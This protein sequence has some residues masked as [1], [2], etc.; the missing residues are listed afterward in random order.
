MPV[1]ERT[2]CASKAAR[3]RLARRVRSIDETAQPYYPSEDDILS[4]EGEQLGILEVP[5]NGILVDYVTGEEM[6][7]MFQANWSSGALPEP[8]V[9]S[10]GYHNTFSW[11][12][13]ERLHMVMD[14]L[15][16]HLASQDGGPVVYAR[17]RDLPLVW[18]AP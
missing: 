7:E 12:F 9:Y 1:S 3:S 13:K 2:N 5:D 14:H 10:F 16:L 4:S 18:P 11:A 15:D 6:I 8:R 17:L